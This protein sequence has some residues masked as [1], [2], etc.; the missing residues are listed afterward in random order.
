M[1]LVNN[2]TLYVGTNGNDDHDGGQKDMY[3]LGGDDSLWGSTFNRA[4][5]LYGG[6]GGDQLIGNNYADQLYGGNGADVL[7][8]DYGNDYL[9]GGDGPD[10][11][12]FDTALNKKKNVDTIA[13]FVSGSG[14]DV[15]WLSK[16]IF[17]GIGN[18]DTFLKA[19]KFE[20]GGNAS[21]SKT[22]ILYN[23]NKG[24]AYYTKKGSEGNKVKFAE[25]T[26]GLSLENDDFYIIA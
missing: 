6:N 7:Y 11:F 26:P 4:Y 9:N 23:E 22:R 10:A 25:L 18:V 24:I 1:A 14:G 21:D 13:D 16:S 19:S 5:T 3:G 20:V 17:K 2:A 12:V 15:F 8:G